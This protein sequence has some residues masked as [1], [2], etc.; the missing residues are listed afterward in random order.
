MSESDLHAM[1]YQIVIHPIYG[2]GA[3][4]RSLAAAYGQLRASGRQDANVD[5]IHRLN[6][7]V[8]FQRIW[9]LDDEFSAR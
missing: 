3:A 2:L 6:E 8:D 1:G 4:T 5:D 7:I 9:S